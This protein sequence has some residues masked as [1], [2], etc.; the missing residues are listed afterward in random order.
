MIVLTRGAAAPYVLESGHLVQCER[1][2]PA[3]LCD[4]LNLLLGRKAANDGGNMLMHKN[5]T[6]SRLREA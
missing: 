4:F 1:P 6:I 2:H 3:D 5:E